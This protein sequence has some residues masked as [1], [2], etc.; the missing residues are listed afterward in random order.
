MCCDTDARL[1]HKTG[2][3]LLTSSSEGLGE[4]AHTWA[5]FLAVLSR[6]NREH[7]VPAIAIP[8]ASEIQHPSQV[9]WMWRSESANPI[10][11]SQILQKHQAQ[12][13]A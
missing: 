8:P 13:S 9:P 2:V 11:G 5:S 10:C 1:R 7:L 4:L 6:G 12:G 3:A